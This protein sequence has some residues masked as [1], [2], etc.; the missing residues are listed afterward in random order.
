MSS[1]VTSRTTDVN[2]DG[3]YCDLVLLHD[4]SCPIHGFHR[5]HLGGEGAAALC[6]L[7]CNADVDAGSVPRLSFSLSSSGAWGFVRA[8]TWDIVT[9]RGFGTYVRRDE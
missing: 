9:V 5:M 3:A 6:E 8:P 2:L 1:L 7:S 4:A